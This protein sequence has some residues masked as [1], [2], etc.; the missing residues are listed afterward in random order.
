VDSAGVLQTARTNL[1]LR[2]EEFDNAYWIKSASTVTLNATA[3]PD[4]VTTADKLVETA[5][6]NQHYVGA[7]SLNLASNVYTS[8]IFAK[9][10]ERTEISIFMD[11]SVTRRV[12]FFNLSTG[13][14]GTNSGGITSSIQAFPN[15]WYKC[16]ITLNAAETLLNVV[17]TTAL[18][19]SNN[20]LGNA[21]SGV[22]LWGA[23]LEQA[24][25]VGEYLPTTSVVNS[26]PR[27]DHNPTTGESLGLLVEEPRTNS[28]RNSTGVGAVAGTPGT[29]PTNWS[30]ATT[31]TGL[32]RE[33]VGTG[34]E[35]GISYIDIR[36][37]GTAT[38]TDAYA[39]V[40]EQGTEIVASTGQSW[41]ASVYTRISGGSTTGVTGTSIRVR[42]RT[43]SGV[44]LGSTSAS[45]TNPANLK[46]GRS[47]ATRVLSDATAARVNSDVIISYSNGS[48]IDIT[49]RIGLPQLEQGAFATSVIPTTTTTVNRAAD[50]AS[51]TGSAFSSWYRQDEG[52]IYVQGSTSA[53]A[54][55]PALFQADDGTTNERIQIRRIGASNLASLFV[56]DGGVSQGSVTV[57]GFNADT[58]GRICTVYALNNLQL[59]FN[60]ALGTADTSATIPT[61]DRAS[62]GSANSA[63]YANGHISRLTYWP[64][65]L[66][67][68]TL[69][70]LTG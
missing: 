9:A 51:I 64:Q 31:Q 45:L 39:I 55:N 56:V 63:G 18:S 30:A 17:Y 49:I 38:A 33:I 3:A 25:T 70:G 2:S 24:S 37:F 7:I 27:F 46:D 69:Q 21:T 14:L 4:G 68:S 65:R 52:T 57:S 42:E 13:T 35:N 19:G 44:V 15:G 16:S 43:S 32:S 41:T 40:F 1:L 48:V 54:A 11:T 29:L 66:A 12:Q 26:A 59:A 53:S 6:S 28:I 20:Y 67:N 60:G 62:I 36:I 34:T 61:V 22:F 58:I 5:V 8:S 10:A 47:V 50:V 23:Q